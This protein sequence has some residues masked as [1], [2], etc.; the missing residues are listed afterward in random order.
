MQDNFQSG[1]Y[2]RSGTTVTVTK[3]SHGCQNGDVIYADFIS[4][5]GTDG[6]YT[7]ANVAANTFEITDTA[8]GTTSGNITYKKADAY[9]TIASNDGTYLFI[10]GKGVGEFTTGVPTGKTGVIAGDAQL[11]TAQKQF[12]TA[13]L[14]LDGTTDHLNYPTAEDFGF[15]TTN[16]A[17]ECFIRPA[18][19]TGTQYFLDFR[20]ASATDTAPVLYLNGTTLHFAVG[21]T[22]QISGGTLSAN[23]WYHVAVARNGG[24]TRLFLDG[25]LLGTY[26]DS[27]DYGSTKPLGIGGQYSGVDEFGGHIDEI[28]VSKAASRYTAAFTAPT[29]AFTTDLF[30]VLLLHFDGTDG[31]TTIADSGKGVRDIRSSGGDSATSLLTVT[32]LS[33]VLSCVLF[34]LQTFMAPRVLLLMVLVSNCS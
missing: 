25:T 30:T 10:S 18:A 8:S 20:D 24:T 32:M 34:L 26:S 1:T 28:R 5:S 13:S 4:G 29:S 3:N 9:G 23:T 12:G 15:G 17:A 7:V 33:L 16:W 21:N 31:S 2:S 22:S 6:Y 27:N 14:V 19:V 11:D